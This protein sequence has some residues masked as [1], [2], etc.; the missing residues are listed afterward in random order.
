MTVSPGATV[1]PEGVHFAVTAREAE[2]VT[3]SLFEGNDETRFAMLREGELHHLFVPGTR[4]RQAYGFRAH[5]AWAPDQG[6]SFDD[7]KLL[8]DPYALALDRPYVFDPRLAE[9]G[10]DTASLVPKSIV[11]DP[12]ELAL[13]PPLF[14]PGGFIYELNVRGISMRH[15]DIPP[16][17]RG[18]IAALAHPAI[19]AH[20][21]RLKVDA[22]ELMPVTAWIDERH[23]PPLGLHNA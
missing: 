1:N 15:P 22:V 16:A 17:L 11:C 2:R 3:L 14:R 18:T 5:G 8:A 12:P 9:R 21:T 6:L 20:L 4:A 13:A 10:F 19:L 23:L 7:S